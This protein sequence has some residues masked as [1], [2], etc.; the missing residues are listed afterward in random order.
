MVYAARVI[1]N[2]RM[3]PSTDARLLKF[4]GDRIRVEIEIEKPMGDVKGFLRTT[5][6]NDKILRQ[7]AM[8][9]ITGEEFLAG[10]EWR[11]VEM[12]TVDNKVW[13]VEF[14]LTE[15]GFFLFKGYLEDMDGN[16]FWPEGENGGISVHP[17]ALRA[18]NTIY[19]A[20]TRLFGKTR[21]LKSGK[22]GLLEAQFQAFDKY[23]HTV[24]PPSGTFRDL[25][26]QL[27]HII[28]D[29]GCRVLHLLPVN[30]T[31]TTTARMGRY[32][33]PY[34]SLDL[35][36]IDPALVE[37]DRRTTGIDQFTELTREAHHLGGRVMLDLVINHTGWHSQMYEHRPDWFVRDDTGEFKSPGA[38]GVV[39]GDLVELDHAHDDLWKHLA[40]IF[41]RWCR[42]GVDGF[43]CDAGY[44]IP[45]PVWEAI[46]ARV[47]DEF[48]ETIFFLEGLGGAFSLTEKLL[49]DGRMQW[50]Y[51]ELFQNY[52]GPA[53][54]Y[55]NDH[56]IQKNK[57]VGLLVHF[58]ETHD[59]DRLAAKGKKWS[60]F[61]NRL[62][63]LTSH[64]GGFGFM[65]GVEWLADEKIDVHQCGGLNFGA[66][67]N[68]VDEISTLNYLI[69]NHPCFVD[70]AVCRRT[71]DSKSSLY[72]LER[73]YCSESE[74]CS[75]LLVAAN[76]DMD[77]S[78]KAFIDKDTVLRLGNSPVDLLGQAAPSLEINPDGTGFITLNG[79]DIFCLSK[80]PFN[81]SVEKNGRY[82]TRR[83]QQGMAVL[84]LSQRFMPEQIGPYNWKEL[85]LLFNENPGGYLGAASTVSPDKIKESLVSSLKEEIAKYTYNPVVVWEVK[86]SSKITPVPF[87]HWLMILHTAP[88]R[89]RFSADNN[90]KK[91]SYSSIYTAKGH[92]AVIPPDE[93]KGDVKIEMDS[94]TLDGF[95]KGN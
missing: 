6:G 42:R 90:M 55:Y 70:G 58:S 93:F 8:V 89:T 30:P 27:P 83:K 81:N 21:T 4:V 87:G 54:S 12:A 40:D 37:F 79:G 47:R 60:L 92:V 76:T 68:I 80:E 52:D 10:S 41:I 34:A 18:E 84:A 94:V 23:G 38:W 36:G 45:V 32:G 78:H 71:S 53:V 50:A 85:A 2:I 51:S 20:F 88:F 56:S 35:A 28:N 62:C 95:I 65:C 48:P 86:D 67:E 17:S 31:P 26:K 24:I 16:T 69:R 9:P 43:R 74:K 64:S 75:Y 63:G 57:E 15:P 44:M 61:R 39:W 11:N 29:L 5:L 91:R 73:T 7:K 19:C 82:L 77:N 25:I 14:T 1:K 59:N 33:S 22:D 66:T 49:T 46:T 13:S 72:L 3:N